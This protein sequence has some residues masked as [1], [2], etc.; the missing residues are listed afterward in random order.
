MPD[1]PCLGVCACIVCA[2]LLLAHSP[3]LLL[4]LLPGCACLRHVRLCGSLAPAAAALLPL[5]TPAQMDEG[6]RLKGKKT[7]KEFLCCCCQPRV[8]EGGAS[9]PGQDMHEEQGLLNERQATEM[10]RNNKL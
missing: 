3:L 7:L 4:P 8:K 1:S 5:P 10:K 9:Q 6:R 2:P